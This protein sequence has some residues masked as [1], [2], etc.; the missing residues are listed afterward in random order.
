MNKAIPPDWLLRSRLRLRQLRLLVALNEHR[1]LRRAAAVLHIAQPAATKLLQEMEDTLGVALFERHARGMEPTVYGEIMTRHAYAALA[2]LTHAREELEAVHAGAS[3]KISIGAIMGAVP[4]LLTMA[5][6]RLREASPRVL[7]HIQVDTSDVLLPRVVD[8][9]L[10]IAVA[11]LTEEQHEG[12]ECTPLADE[13]IV[14]V[15]ATDH[16]LAHKRN[17]TLADLAQWPWILQATTSPMR[18]QLDLM[19]QRAGL[20]IPA[21]RI[22]TA[23]IL[24]TTALLQGTR[25][26]AAV[27]LE[28]AQH[29]ETRR[30]LAILPVKLDCGLGSYGVIT[31]AGRPLSPAAQR[32]ITMLREVVQQA[33]Q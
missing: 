27:P 12:F 5:L 32:F 33:Q 31:A 13:T 11:R 18:R 15:V 1:N 10:D 22:E 3:G 20:P 7:V 30:L 9:A 6:A 16:P 28:V 14:A 26:V 29:Y 24:A 23:S 21:E 19:F 25:M 4:Q 2:N 8:G 17:A